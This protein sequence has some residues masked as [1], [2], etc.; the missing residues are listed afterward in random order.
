MIYLVGLVFLVLIATGA[1]LL[2]D[3]SA[4]LPSSGAS[5]SPL[6]AG[7]AKLIDLDL[8][9]GRGEKELADQQ[10][11]T[12][13]AEDRD[14][15]QRNLQELEEASHKADKETKE[16]RVAIDSLGDE[17]IEYRKNRRLILRQR[18]MGSVLETLTLPSGKTYEQVEISQI[19]N[20]GVSIKHRYGSSR[21]RVADLPR[22]MRRD[23][24]LNLDEAEAAL[25]KEQAAKKVFLTEIAEKKKALDEEKK[26]ERAAAKAP[27]IPLLKQKV[28]LL[29]TKRSQALREAATA[30]RN[31]AH[32]S[33]RSGP[34]GL[35]TWSGRAQRMDRN[36]NRY[37]LQAQSLIAVIKAHEAGY[38]APE[39][40]G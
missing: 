11:R 14:E 25:K 20:A 19:D 2:I 10:I 28:R 27:D 17:W 12:E 26:A 5:S 32:S 37:L 24:D 1:S 4:V 36:A 40:G 22:Q 13:R 3:K 18:M 15:L 35:E 39:I 8:E 9:I 38:D 16:L 21:I 7:N 6:V 34:D 33:N 30:R 23:L 31:D 29:I